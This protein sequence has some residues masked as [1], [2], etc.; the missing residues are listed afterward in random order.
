[1]AN[2]F[3][4]SD[5]HIGHKNICNFRPQFESIEDHNN[6]IKENYHK[7]VTKRDV[8]FML[9]DMAFT[10]EA[11]SDIKSWRAERKILI[12]GNHDLERGISMKDLCNT[13]DAVYSFFKYKNMWLTHA[14]I[15]PDELRGKVCLHGHTHYHN[16]DDSRYVNVSM[17]QI[18]YTPIELHEIRRKLYVSN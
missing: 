14:P 4:M 7:V 15:H 3:F 13:Y 12:C 16:I 11:L 2:V 1:M 17:E 6:T 5:A 8:V 10:H 9:G 18:N